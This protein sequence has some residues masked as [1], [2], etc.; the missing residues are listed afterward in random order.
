MPG[1]GER[2]LVCAVVEL[3]LLDQAH[4]GGAVQVRV[5]APVIDGIEFY[6]EHFEADVL[7]RGDASDGK[8]TTAVNHAALAIAD[9]R[10]YLLPDRLR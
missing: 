5:Q 3:A 1:V 2:I 9:K 4:L 8:D 10:V 7:E 6:R